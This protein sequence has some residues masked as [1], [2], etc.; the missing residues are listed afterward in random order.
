[1]LFIPLQGFTQK[2]GCFHTL[3]VIR[4]A[5]DKIA[6]WDAMKGNHQIIWFAGFFNSRFY[7]FGQGVNIAFVIMPR[8]DSANGWLPA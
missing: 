6:L 5:G 3:A 1:M 2:A 4:V 7:R 8:R